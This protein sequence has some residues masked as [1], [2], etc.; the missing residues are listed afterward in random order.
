MPPAF[1]QAAGLSSAAADALLDCA[2][3]GSHSGMADAGKQLLLDAA[4]NKQRAFATHDDLVHVRL[5]ADYAE[6]WVSGEH[7]TFSTFYMCRAVNPPCNTVILSQCWETL[8]E[9]PAAAGQR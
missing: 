1:D 8:K 4:A 7:G 6:Q 3:T 2:V 5:A 9:D